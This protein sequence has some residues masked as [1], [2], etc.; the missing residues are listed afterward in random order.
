VFIW[1]YVISSLRVRHHSPSSLGCDSLA[2]SRCPRLQ[3][4]FFVPCFPFFPVQDDDFYFID[5]FFPLLG[6]PTCKPGDTEGRVRRYMH[7]RTL[8]PVDNILVERPTLRPF[9]LPCPTRASLRKV[10][11]DRENSIPTFTVPPR[12]SSIGLHA[13]RHWH[14]SKPRSTHLASRNS[15]SRRPQTGL[16]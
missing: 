16:T 10:N 15:A 4:L 14:S 13:H 9:T 7:P 1:L 8:I 2:L 5:E 12:A 11:L 6:L 3:A